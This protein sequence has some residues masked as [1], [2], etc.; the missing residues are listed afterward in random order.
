MGW[1][2]ITNGFRGA[3]G[4]H[5]T[6][7]YAISAICSFFSISPRVSGKLKLLHL[8]GCNQMIVKMFLIIYNNNKLA[9]IP[10][11]MG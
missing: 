4:G 11:Q 7:T 2:S 8:F 10:S 1:H 9:G 6:R 3:H 5:Q